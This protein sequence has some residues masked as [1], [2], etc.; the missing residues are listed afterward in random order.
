MAVREGDRRSGVASALIRAS[1]A[2]AGSWG[3]DSVVLN[4]FEANTPAVRLYERNGFAREA[5]DPDWVTLVG[6]KKRLYM[7]KR[8]AKAP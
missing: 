6:R 3:Q 5:A 7:A 8:V 2:V 4:V 1:E